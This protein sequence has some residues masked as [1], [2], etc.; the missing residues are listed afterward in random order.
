MPVTGNARLVAQ[1]FEFPGELLLLFLE[2][3]VKIANWRAGIH[4]HLAVVPI[5]DNGSVLE[6]VDGHVDRTHY[7]RDAQRVGENR[8]VGVARSLEG[9]DAAQALDGQVGHHRGGKFLRHEN[10]VVGI[11]PSGVADLL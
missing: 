8:A 6:F 2:A 1:R 11:A 5:D 9:D 7:R 3:L 10:H 4:E